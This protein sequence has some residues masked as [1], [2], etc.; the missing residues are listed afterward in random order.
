MSWN[1][2]AQDAGVSF[3][4]RPKLNRA[5]AINEIVSG[6]NSSRKILFDKTGLITIPSPELPSDYF[7]DTVTTVMSQGLSSRSRSKLTKLQYVI[8]DESISRH[9]V[10]AYYSHESDAL[11]IGKTHEEGGSD[12]QK[13][14]AH[15]MSII[16]HEL[17]HAYA[18]SN[19]SAERL[20][21]LA[22]RFGPW[23]FYTPNAS[24]HLFSP[25]FFTPHPFFGAPAG[26]ISQLDNA[27]SRYALQNIHEWFAECFSVALRNN[28]RRQGLYP[29]ISGASEVNSR[30][31]STTLNTWITE[32]L[33]E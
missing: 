15:T 23:K 20:G 7:L 27:P 22:R 26:A 30:P 8:A 9:G 2:N 28:L 24:D 25:P 4:I 31:L 29:N 18:M 3:T 14:L 32:S 1:A 21:H 6:E 12:P 16:A 13:H 17:G 11:I 10:D 33:N 19:L 5:K